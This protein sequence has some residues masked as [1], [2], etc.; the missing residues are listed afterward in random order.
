MSTLFYNTYS[1]EFFNDVSHELI[2]QFIKELNVRNFEFN[3]RKGVLNRN[4]WKN[5]FENYPI[6]YKGMKWDAFKQKAVE[7]PFQ[8]KINNVG[9]DDFLEVSNKFFNKFKDKKIAVQLS[10]GLDSS[11]IIGLLS[12]FKIPF[13][14]VGISS[15]RYEFR[16][17]KVIQ[18][19]LGKLSNDSILLDFESYLPF[20]DLKN[21]PTHCYPDIH[22][23][24]FTTQ[25]GMAQV[26]QDLGIEIFL[27]GDGGD[28]LLGEAIP[29]ST[30]QFRCYPQVFCP[31]WI[32]ENVYSPKGIELISFYSNNL[33]IDVLYNLRRGQKADNSKLWAR[34]FCSRILP[35]ELTDFDYKADFWGLYQSGFFNAIEE[36]NILIHQAYDV[37]KIEQFA[38]KEW[39]PLIGKNLN[40]M[41]KNLYQIIE[42]RI[43][44]AIWINSLKL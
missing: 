27:T 12:F 43:A 21:I 34:N 26:C 40:R 28:I 15:N 22:A 7:V 9:W 8:P 36:I 31:E 6:I 39:N 4:E 42:S 44:L 1:Q 20:G 33:I 38:P 30:D 3:T 25:N 5:I 16:T 29:S 23:I 37:F 10:G 13:W 41:D 14:T 2:F 17:E 35:N 11:I 24:N 19:L 18:K 32:Q